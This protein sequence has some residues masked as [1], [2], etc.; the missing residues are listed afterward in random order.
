M[1]RQN[2]LLLILLVILVLGMVGSFLARKAFLAS[3]G[4]LPVAL[5]GSMSGP[6]AEAGL[7]LSRGAELAIDEIN[8]SG[9]LDR[10]RLQA[11]VFD[12]AGSP[13]KAREI[14]GKIARE[15]R[16]VVVIGGNSA[17]VAEAL[18][19]A[20]S[21]EKK[22]PFLTT[23]AGGTAISQGGDWSFKTAL[24]DGQ[25]ARF[26]ANYNRNV[27]NRKLVTIVQEE[28][29][30]G[31]ALARGFQETY[32]KFGT[33]IPIVWSFA[34][35]NDE[36][37]TFQAV[38]DQIKASRDLS[39]IFLAMGSAEAA[40]FVK[41]AREGRL[42]NDIVGPDTL[43]SN[44]FVRGLVDLVGE[45]NA[46]DYLHDT[47]VTSSLIWDTAGEAAQGFKNRYRSR[48]DGPPDWV[49]SQAFD[50]VHMAARGMLEVMHAAGNENPD[51]ADLVLRGRQ[52]IRDFLVARNSPEK[53]YPGVS[54]MVYFEK[55]REASRPVQVGRYDGLNLI[56]AM[57]QLE[58]IRKK[59]RV[60]YL[61]EIKSGRMLYVND[62]FMFK[63]NVVYTGLTLKEVSKVENED[64]SAEV[65]F[66]L[67]FRH[68][69]NAVNF[70]PQQ[71]E[72]L[73]AVTPIE[74]GKPVEE[75]VR[76]GLVFKLYEVKGRF[77]LNSLEADRPYGSQVVGV[78]F[79]HRFLNRNNLVLV[80][81]ELGMKGKSGQNLAE[82]IEESQALHP[83]LEWEVNKAWL[84]SENSLTF[85]LGRPQYVGY[86]TEEPVFSRIDFGI[87]VSPE[88]FS[89]RDVVADEYFVYITIFAFIGI[90]FAIGIDLNAK[91]MF[92]SISSYGL[93]LFF[94]PLL[95]ISL[96]QIV[97]DFS[98]NNLVASITDRIDLVYNALLW[99]L[100]ARL[101][102]VALERFVWQ[103]LEHRTERMVPNIIR[104]FAAM[105]LYVLAIC[106]VVAFVLDEALTSLLATS[107]LLAMI[108]GLA[109]QANI[110]NVFSG[111][112]VNIE[113]PF[114]VGD[115]VKIGSLDD[116]QVIDIT[117]RTMR[118]Q[119]VNGHV[120]S[121]PNG[122]ASESSVVNY[123]AAGHVRIR[124]VVTVSPTYP[125][126]MILGILEAAANS[127]PEISSVKKASFVFLGVDKS[128]AQY[129]AWLWLN[130]FVDDSVV[131]AFWKAVWTHFQ[132]NDI[133]LQ[134]SPRD[135]GK[136]DSRP[137]AEQQ[138]PATK[139]RPDWIQSYLEEVVA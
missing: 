117:W 4:S 113:R 83:S 86:G 54:G 69:E 27:L 35:G 12:D 51:E 93:H 103:P 77:F 81:D 7:A 134:P 107:G 115:W 6:E 135:A 105:V 78:S 97:L 124:T 40:H 118:L 25:Q 36:A 123:T 5:I 68:A 22:L 46:A 84:A 139:R 45:E 89:L 23:A 80:V 48:F 91:G 131:Q 138:S 56:S 132:A 49:A 55:E 114:S 90:I 9:G 102:S 13:E 75:S 70:D 44:L 72:F 38:I 133:S 39:A 62:R 76:K 60:D 19:A 29:P 85:S 16:H 96:G 99:L 26:M 119:T 66:Q 47:Y 125:P 94:W 128:L 116:A 108:I 104:M 136:G 106:G 121:I 2:K 43:A 88:R 73:N 87:Q 14:A 1:S 28:T 79:R 33:S 127:D 15:G 112:V 74:L 32:E 110:A 61:Q 10:F 3:Q 82:R 57:T 58:P 18:S 30:F 21:G 59:G 100:P 98:V 120:I 42:R 8:E 137:K 64:H 126:Q 92:W 67:W 52:W 11:E 109:V 65:A 95:L 50:A 130:D 37:A 17:P 20:L 71:L 101:G 53:A 122:K 31:D 41:L 63:T 111:I 129:E 34:P 24:N